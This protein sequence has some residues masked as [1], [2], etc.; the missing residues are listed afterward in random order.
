MGLPPAA[1]I[2]NG[3]LANGPASDY[4]VTIGDPYIVSG[5]TYTPSDVW[6]YDEVGYVVMD[7]AGGSTISGSN[8]TLPL[9]SYV[10]VTSL[11]T[12]KTIL[13]RLERRGPMNGAQLIGLSPGA[14]A[15]LGLSPTTAVRVRRVN[16]PEAERSALRA[17]QRVPDRMDT[18]MSLVAV[19]KLKL[20]GGAVPATVA[21]DYG[22]NSGLTLPPLDGAY[23]PP[24]P[25]KRPPRGSR[26]RRDPLRVR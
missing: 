12:G 11:D 10:E 2:A 23:A 4:P 17:G 25:V 1:S 19:L 26:A 6:N 21:S 14:I 13:V 9:P 24:P 15:Q 8:H 20:P 7:R 22:S 3:G 16:P 5:V 18:P